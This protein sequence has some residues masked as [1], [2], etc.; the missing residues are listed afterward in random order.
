MENICH[1]FKELNG[2]PSGHR[3]HDVGIYLTRLDIGGPSGYAPVGGMCNPR[4]SCSLN[5]DE[6]LTSAFVIAHEIG[7]VLGFSHDGDEEEGNTCSQDGGDGGVMAPLVLATFTHFR[8]SKCTVNEYRNKINKW[9]CLND[10]PM[11]LP[12]RTSLLT[13][14]GRQYTL[15]EQC[16]MEFG[17]NFLLCRSF[18]L[19]DPCTHL[20]CSNR[21][22][23]LMCKTKKGP[24]LE[25]TPCGKGKWCAQG[26]CQ[27]INRKKFVWDPVLYNPRHGSWGKWTPFGDCSRSCGTGVRFR[28]RK[29]DSPRPTFGGKLCSGLYEEFTLCN[30]QACPVSRDFRAEQCAKLPE[31]SGQ[32]RKRS[33]EFWIPYTAINE[34]SVCKLACEAKQTGEIFISQDNVIDGTLCSYDLPHHLCIQGQCQEVGCDG[35]LGSNKTEDSCGVCGGNDSS[36][37]DVQKLLVRLP[38]KPLSRLLVLPRGAKRIQV[39]E[40]SNTANRLVLQRR[41]TKEI[42]LNED[43][44]G[45]ANKTVVCEGTKFV[46]VRNSSSEVITGTGPLLDEVILMLGAATQESDTMVTVRYTISVRKDPYYERPFL[47]DDRNWSPCSKSCEGGEQFIKLLCRERRSERVVSKRF[48]SILEKPAS[49]TRPCNTFSCTYR[50]RVGPW[51]HCTHT[52]GSR[53]FQHRQITCIPINDTAAIVDPVLCQDMKLEQMISCNRVPCPSQWQTGL[54]SKCSVTC[55]V[56]VQ[57]RKVHCLAPDNEIHYD[58]VGRPHEFRKCH[59]GSCTGNHLFVVANNNNALTISQDLILTLYRGHMFQRHFGVLPTESTPPVLPNSKL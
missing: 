45:P 56:G 51:E 13:P 4:R 59:M 16:R 24:P 57:T 49:K 58:C 7:H 39:K 48:C 23:P 15:D 42:V 34:S 50:W 1:W 31:G 20:W 5:R 32:H 11:S 27:F 46:Y 22:T 28:T 2:G 36:C 29:C 43:Q 9:F 17:H 40:I 19:S 44:E 6:G 21:S 30:K 3:K 26:F 18:M 47:W 55:G 33:K 8:W 54:W 41:L 35:L 25:G 52:C 10:R 38:T 37:K 12:S 53:G 14:L